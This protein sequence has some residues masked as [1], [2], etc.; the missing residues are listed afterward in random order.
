MPKYIQPIVVGNKRYYAVYSTVVMDFVT[1]YFPS[2]ELLKK[3]YPQ[4]RNLKVAREPLR[5]RI[6]EDGKL[7]VTMKVYRFDLNDML[8]K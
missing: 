1:P 6:R 7:E 4:Y 8:K 3:R 5:G 2:L